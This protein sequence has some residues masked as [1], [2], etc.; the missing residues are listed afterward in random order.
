MKI[1]ILAAG[2][3][4]CNLAGLAQAADPAADSTG[5]RKL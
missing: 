4:A 2:L 3:L 1:F 5:R